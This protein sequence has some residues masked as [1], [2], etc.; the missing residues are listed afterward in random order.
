MHNSSSIDFC[1]IINHK[2]HFLFLLNFISSSSKEFLIAELQSNM[3]KSMY[4][5]CS[6]KTNT[7]IITLE[8][9]QIFFKHGQLF[10]FRF[11]GAAS[12]FYLLTRML[13]C[14]K[15][16]MFTFMSAS[17]EDTQ[18]TSMW[19]FMWIAIRSILVLSSKLQ[20]THTNFNSPK[21]QF[22]KTLLKTCVDICQWV[23]FKQRQ[24][25]VP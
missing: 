3:D 25:H 6:E 18:D 17:S 23:G 5:G 13:Y 7:K 15:L 24:V 2:L 22:L 12:V 1:F 21:V 14:L 19:H 16:K 9:F 10:R 4:I 8:N 11:Y 20:F